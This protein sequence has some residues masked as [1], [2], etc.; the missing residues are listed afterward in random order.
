[1]QVVEKTDFQKF[2]QLSNSIRK[3][4]LEMVY[5]AKS[6]H[7]GPSFSCVEILVS[8][9]FKV[10]NIDPK[11]P[12][13]PERDRF[14][15]SKGHAS[16]ALYA[17]LAERGYFT[18]TELK[19]FRQFNS[20]L[21]GHPD[22]RKT[23]GLDVSSGSLGNGLSVASGLSAGLKNSKNNVYVLLGDGECQEGIIWEAAMSAAKYKLNNL[24]AIIDKNNFQTDGSLQEIMPLGDIKEKF[25]SFGW[26]CLEV[27]GH[28]YSQIIEAT[29]YKSNDSPILIIANTVKGKGVSFMEGDYKWHSTPPTT[30]EYIRALEELKED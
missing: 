10:M 29:T 15:L 23:V 24:Y 16:P 26:K 7:I 13:M 3:A 18:K 27:N 17:T 22:I 5:D 2:K 6:G 25:T 12:Y 19:Q 28:N 1:M 4:I 9:Y 8:L 14:V 21:Q 30:E 11:Q 20:T